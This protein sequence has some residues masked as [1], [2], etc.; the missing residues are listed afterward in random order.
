MVSCER[1]GDVPVHRAALINVQRRARR[2]HIRSSG[3]TKSL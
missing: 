3:T 2:Y 1:E